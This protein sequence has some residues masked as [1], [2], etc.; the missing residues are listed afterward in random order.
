MHDSHPD[1]F[2]EAVDKGA[3][4]L[5]HPHHQPERAPRSLLPWCERGD[6][7]YPTSNLVF[8]MQLAVRTSPRRKHG[9]ME[10]PVF[11]GVLK[12][13]CFFEWAVKATQKGR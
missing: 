9:R 13:P 7:G 3:E 12:G 11:I 6:V 1:L 8:T 2:S 10:K 5:G 4:F